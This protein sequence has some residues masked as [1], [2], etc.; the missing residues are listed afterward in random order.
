MADEKIPEMHLHHLNPPFSPRP[1]P[2]EPPTLPSSS[3]PTSPA[4]HV[5]LDTATSLPLSPLASLPTI[6]GKGNACYLANSDIPQFLASDLDL[7]RLNRIHS[8]L[9]MA[10]R[11]MRARPLHRYRMLGYEV[12]GTMQMDLHLLKFSNEI[13]IKPLPE[14][15]VS[16]EFWA[17]YLCHDGAGDLHK[18][19][20]GWLLSYIWLITTPLDLKF[21]HEHSLLPSFVTWMWWKEFVADFVCHV[22]VN[23][24]D[25]VNMRYQFGDLRLG[26][27]NSIYRFRFCFT[28]FVRGYL[29]GYNRY[30]VFFERN[31]SWILVVFVFFS[32]VLSAMQ[33]GA[34]LDELKTNHA[35]LQGSYVFV[36]FSMM[37]VVAVLAVVCVFFVVIFLF[38]MAAAIGHAKSEQKKRKK[39]AEGRSQGKEV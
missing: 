17:Q 29:Y 18:S 33:V 26:R 27:I 23:A 38:N 16:Y 3:S 5:A 9:W 6:A 15:M 22:D 35:F 7:S 28:H 25:Q 39:M 32:L 37:S 12:L 10:G 19:A 11:P 36:V 21:A 14:W 20:C 31:F 13:L 1:I 4:P 34:G 2:P 30:V 8:H 24:L